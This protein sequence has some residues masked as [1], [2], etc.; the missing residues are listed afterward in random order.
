MNEVP[1]QVLRE[2][3]SVICGRGVTQKQINGKEYYLLWMQEHTM[4]V[5]ERHYEKVG[6]DFEQVHESYRIFHPAFTEGW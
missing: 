6:E 1:K 3:S 4:Q 5:K 2:I